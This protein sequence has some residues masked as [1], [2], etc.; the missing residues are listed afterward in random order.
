MHCRILWKI[1]SG[2]QISV[3]IW[4]YRSSQTF[5]LQSLGRRAR[6]T[7]SQTCAG[8][9]CCCQFCKMPARLLCG[10]GTRLSWGNEGRW[11]FCPHGYARQ[12]N[13][14]QS[15]GGSR[16]YRCSPADIANL[17]P[18]DWGSC[19]PPQWRTPRSIR[20]PSRSGLQKVP[21]GTAPGRSC[22]TSLSCHYRAAGLWC[23]W[24]F[25]CFLRCTAPCKLS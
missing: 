5:R 12:S 25:C 20:S 1:F 16:I 7:W 15:R 6:Q 23:G 3:F 14:Y 22:R 13:P 19:R 17:C 9:P 4:H 21:R 18:S 2:F 11:W 10:P 24:L 8:G